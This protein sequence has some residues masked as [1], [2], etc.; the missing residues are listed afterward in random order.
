M[1][2]KCCS[3]IVNVLSCHG[4]KCNVQLHLP[5]VSF[6]HKHILTGQLRRDYATSWR[7]Y[8]RRWAQFDSK[9]QKSRH[10]FKVDKGHSY[11]RKS[12]LENIKWLKRFL[13]KQNSQPQF[14]FARSLHR[15]SISL[16]VTMHENIGMISEKTQYRRISC[17]G[18]K[19][20]SM[21]RFQSGQQPSSV[22][23]KCI[24]K[25]ATIRAC[26]FDFHHWWKT[27]RI[28]LR[29]KLQLQFH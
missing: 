2:L 5:N 19:Q 12:S 17:W 1:A 18:E 23:K 21:K 8:W 9:E 29:C 14:P 26:G 6:S 25:K 16:F 27:R 24:E 22:T 7:G 28:F 11:W 4:S 13:P 3:R 20:G 10:S 15:S